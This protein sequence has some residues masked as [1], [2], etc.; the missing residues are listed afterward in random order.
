MR[1]F[2]NEINKLEINIQRR[3]GMDIDNNI[4]YDTIP[5]DIK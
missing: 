4:I 1:I 3:N 2:V 5:Y